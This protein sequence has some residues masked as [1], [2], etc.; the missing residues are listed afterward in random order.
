MTFAEWLEREELPR[1]RQQFER[2]DYSAFMEGLLFCCWNAQPLPDWIAI[3]VIDQ[4]EDVFAKAST[5]P[6]RHGNWSARDAALQ[7]E[8]MR[9]G[10]ADFHLRA[11]QRRGRFFVSELARVFGYGREIPGDSVNIVTRTDV[12]EFVSQQLKGKPA[13]GSPAAI[14][15]AYKAS[16]RKRGG[17]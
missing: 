7:I 13:Q 16:R 6:G 10:M 15:A 17:E 2:G 5:G 9:A 1:L 11:R 4:A 14:E 8:T 12:F 3:I